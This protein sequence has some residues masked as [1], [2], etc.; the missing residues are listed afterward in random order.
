MKKFLWSMMCVGLL[1]SCS[2]D[3]DAVVV[4]S[5]ITG[6]WE[7]QSVILKPEYRED[8]NGDGQAS[9]DILEELP[10]YRTTILDISETIITVNGTEAE[11]LVDFT[12]NYTG[13]CSAPI[14]FSQSL[15]YTFNGNS[16]TVTDP[17]EGFSETLAVQIQG[18]EL[19][20]IFNDP[21][22]EVESEVYLKQ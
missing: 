18:N 15:T 6:T 21:E 17:E 1:W 11:P 5:L 14:S 3:D 12:G 22:D 16:I 4:G 10:C 2:D 19:R 8:F 13:D 7:L 9:A 20:I